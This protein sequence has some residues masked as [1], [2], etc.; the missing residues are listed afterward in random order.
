MLEKGMP[1]KDQQDQ[2]V[3]SQYDLDHPILY[4][5]EL[6]VINDEPYN[7]ENTRKILIY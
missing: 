6:P 2:A 7:P 4:D 1:T 5:Q 3:Y